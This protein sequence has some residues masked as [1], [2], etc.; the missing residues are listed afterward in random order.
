MAEKTANDM[1][2]DAR[3]KATLAHQQRVN[4]IEVARLGTDKEVFSVVRT[5]I[6]DIF[7]DSVLG[8]VGSRTVKA[9]GKAYSRLRDIG[10]D[11]KLA[12]EK[13]QHEEQ[14]ASLDSRRGPVKDKL[15]DLFT[16]RLQDQGTEFSVCV[17]GHER[18]YQQVAGFPR[19]DD[20]PDSCP[21]T[22]IS[23]KD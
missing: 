20:G 18:R 13:R 9:I 21:T 23:L 22:P 10:L 1:I 4:E 12:E 17:N 8:D 6:E 3:A 14:L 15:L 7:G 19:L 11:A 2:A 16:S 5:A